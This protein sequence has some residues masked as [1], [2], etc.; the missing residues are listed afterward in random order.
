M[1]NYDEDKNEVTHKYMEI[2]NDI[3]LYAI[4]FTYF[5]NRNFKI[6]F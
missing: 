3:D 5:V 4:L 6:R 2:K 1:I